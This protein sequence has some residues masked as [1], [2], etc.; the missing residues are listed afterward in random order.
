MQY[1]KTVILKTGEACVIRTA[2]GGDAADVLRC[3]LKRTKKP[4]TC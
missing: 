1:N 3:F 2:E 4:T